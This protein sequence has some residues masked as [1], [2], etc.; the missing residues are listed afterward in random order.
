MEKNDVWQFR[1]KQEINSFK[2]KILN[3]YIY[4]IKCYPKTEKNKGKM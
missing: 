3:V 2:I 1:K 4:D